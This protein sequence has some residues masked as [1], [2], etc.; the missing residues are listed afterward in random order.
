MSSNLEDTQVEWIWA[1][2]VYF[3]TPFILSASLQMLQ[4]SLQSR[5]LS[6]FLTICILRGW[7]GEINCRPKR[8]CTET[9]EGPWIEAWFYPKSFPCLPAAGRWCN[10]GGWACSWRWIHSW[11]EPLTAFHRGLHAAAIICLLQTDQRERTQRHKSTQIHVSPVAA[12]S[13]GGD[14][15]LWRLTTGSQLI[16]WVAAAGDQ[17]CRGAAELAG[18]SCFACSSTV[19]I[20]WNGQFYI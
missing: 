12:G 5:S 18:V 8:F 10:Y 1:L 16:R 2:R 13:S 6:R 17:N 19:E 14:L 11:S 3:F 9:K 7:L 20:T 4:H 15:Q